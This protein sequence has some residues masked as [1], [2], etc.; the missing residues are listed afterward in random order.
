MAQHRTEVRL[1]AL[2]EQVAGLA[3]AQQQTEARVSALTEQMAELAVAQK[4]TEAHMA[5][6]ATA[7]QQTEARMG[8]LADDIGTLKGY[9]LEAQYR[10]K[11]QHYFRQIVRRPHVLT[12][13]ELG[14]LIDDA[15]EQG[16]L[17]TSEA[18]ELAAVDMV[19]RGRHP[20]D[21]HT[22]YLAV[23]VSWGVGHRDVAQATR[24]AALL[25][26]IGMMAAP[27]VA[28]HWVTPEGIQLAQSAPVWQLT[29]GHT[30][31]PTASAPSTG[32]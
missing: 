5:A 24:R 26:Q 3:V 18:D 4:Q 29:N 21:G 8:T 2:T 11:G 7:Q 1:S 13:D 28:G 10:T 30:T 31:P 32:Q 6:L 20:Q 14:A 12:D 22:L 27:V 15:L 16:L 17:S 19:V 9:N 25:G 23:E